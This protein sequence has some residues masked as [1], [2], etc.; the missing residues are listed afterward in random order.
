MF[1]ADKLVDKKIFGYA[2]RYGNDEVGID[3]GSSDELD[4]GVI[5]V[6]LRDINFLCATLYTTVSPGIIFLMLVN[7]I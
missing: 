3:D 1:G 2:F 6:L 4:V 7:T 5:T